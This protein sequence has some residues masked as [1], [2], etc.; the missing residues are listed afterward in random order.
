MRI[1]ISRLGVRSLIVCSLLGLLVY[2]GRVRIAVY[3][4]SLGGFTHFRATLSAENRI[5]SQLVLTVGTQPLLRYG[6]TALGAELIT[7]VNLVAAF[8][9][10]HIVSSSLFRPWL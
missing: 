4:S 8:V 9:T 3:G 10:E 1:L 2:G 5:V 7:F 6:S